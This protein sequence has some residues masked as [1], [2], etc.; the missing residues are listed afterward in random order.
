MTE[1]VK[2][3]KVHGELDIS[4]VYKSGKYFRCR[5]CERIR[6]ATYTRLN[7]DKELA[8]YKAYRNSDRYRKRLPEIA[9]KARKEYHSNKSGRKEKRLAYNLE[10]RENNLERAKRRDAVYYKKIREFL[11][12]PY[13]KRLIKGRTSLKN[14]DI[15]G[16]L[17]DFKKEVIKLHRL[18]RKGALEHEE[19]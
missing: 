17:V 14:S 15:P 8:R 11:L 12:S 19:Y 3:C 18:L 16:L 2:T 7:K 9:E 5:T 4:Q 10:W 6:G 1:I 13:V